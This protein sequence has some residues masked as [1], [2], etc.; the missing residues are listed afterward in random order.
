LPKEK[1]T[2]GHVKQSGKKRWMRPRSYRREFMRTHPGLAAELLTSER[3]KLRALIWSRRIIGAA[4][5]ALVI[6]VWSL[7]LRSR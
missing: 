1:T 7:I 4:A 5:I 2:P 6:A 3:R